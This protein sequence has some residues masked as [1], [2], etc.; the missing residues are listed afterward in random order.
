MF[1]R[2][3]IFILSILHQ[4]KADD[5]LIIGWFYIYDITFIGRKLWPLWLFQNIMTW[6]HVRLTIPTWHHVDYKCVDYVCFTYFSH[7]YLTW[8]DIIYTYHHI[9]YID[10]CITGIYIYIIIFI[11]ISLYM[12]HMCIYIYICTQYIY[13]FT[14]YIYNYIY[15]SIYIYILVGGLEHFYFSIY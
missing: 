8:D 1:H 15:L 2:R 3:S 7:T 5:W 11:H 4:F 14:I 6:H 13:M 9:L 10:M 12:C